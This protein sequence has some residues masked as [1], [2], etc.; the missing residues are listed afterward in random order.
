MENTEELENSKKNLYKSPKSKNQKGTNTAKNQNLSSDK[1]INDNDS[2]QNSLSKLSENA[3]N[4]NSERIK[5]S[6]KKD[7]TDSKSCPFGRF[8]IRRYSPTLPAR[9]SEPINSGVALSP[10]SPPPPPAIHHFLQKTY[11]LPLV[12][13]QKAAALTGF[14]TF[15]IELFWVEHCRALQCESPQRPTR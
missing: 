6:N 3:E 14:S 8:Q 13:L 4:S 15:R 11:A 10:R 7:F 12:W 9:S 1:S 5:S 2:S